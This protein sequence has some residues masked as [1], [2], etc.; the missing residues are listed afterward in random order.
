MKMAAAVFGISRIIMTYAGREYQRRTG[1]AEREKEK[2]K[3]SLVL[4]DGSVTLG[5]CGS[6]AA[7][8][9]GS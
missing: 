4:D 7:S 8:S 6:G 5:G 1:P 2:G 3:G 9:Y